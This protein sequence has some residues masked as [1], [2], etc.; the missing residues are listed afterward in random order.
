M[1]RRLRDIVEGASR[2]ERIRRI[3]RIYEDVSSGRAK[4][5]DPN[6]PGSILEYLLRIEYSLWFYTV[7]LL[8]ALAVVSIVLSHRYTLLYPFRLVFGGL[9]AAFLPGYTIVE[10][11]Y[12][13]EGQLSDIEKLGISIALSL[14]VVPMI[15][16]ILNYTRE[17]ITLERLL[18]LNSTLIIITSMIAL[19]RKYRHV[20]YKEKFS[21]RADALKG[22][23]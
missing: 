17:G 21:G 19:V 20:A 14:A 22:S 3:A 23:P 13:R 12:P 16:F 10:A 15:G 6:P 11:L 5:V 18:I 7:I 4:L 1:S 8:T 2:R 9:F